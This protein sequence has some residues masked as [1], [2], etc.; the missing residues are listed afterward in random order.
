MPFSA[1]CSHE[2]GNE[3]YLVSLS[4]DFQIM[5]RAQAFAKGFVFGRGYI[6]KHEDLLL[7]REVVAVPFPTGTVGRRLIHRVAGLSGFLR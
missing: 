4:F 5:R 7:S 6:K 2:G 1:F 3:S